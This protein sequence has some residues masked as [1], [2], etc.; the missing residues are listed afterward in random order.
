MKFR[1]SGLKSIVIAQ[2][3]RR[4]PEGEIRYEDV[5][6]RIAEMLAKELAIRRY[7]ERLKSAT[8]VEVRSS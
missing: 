5:R 7:L 6:D 8:Y 3:V 4:R 2:V 1:R